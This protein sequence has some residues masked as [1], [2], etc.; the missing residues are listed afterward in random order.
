MGEDTI[1]QKWEQC[2]ISC[3][4]DMLVGGGGGGGGRESFGQENNSSTQKIQ[5]ISLHISFF[6]VFNHL[7]VCRFVAW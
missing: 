5:V 4:L 3:L 1:F 7:T 2:V 6:I